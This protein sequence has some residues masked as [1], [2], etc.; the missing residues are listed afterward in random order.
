MLHNF[1]AQQILAF[2]PF[3]PTQEQDFCI[4]RMAEFCTNHAQN[5]IFMLKGYAGTGKTSVVSALVRA[6]ENLKQHTVLLAPTGRA[7]KVF[8]QYSGKQAISIHKKIYRQKSAT[9][10]TF[11]LDRNKHRDTLFIVD[12]ASM[13][14]NISAESNMFGSGRLLDDLV[15]YVYQAENCKMILLG[16]TAQLLPVNQ[17]FSPALDRKVLESLSLEVDEFTL[18]E[19]VRQASDSGILANA[20]ML[21][22]LLDKPIYENPKI[23]LDFDDIQ[24][25]TGIELIDSI[26][27]SYRE[28]GETDTIVV[29]RSNKRANVFNNGIR[30]QVL[31]CDSE[32][33][34]G[35][36]LMIVKNNYFWSEK[37]V[38]LNFIA[39]GD[40][41]KVVRVRRYSEMYGFRFVDAVLQLLDYDMEI[42]CKILLNSLST[43]IPA[44]NNLLGK[45]LFEEVEKD[46]LHIGNRRQRYL[47]MRE[48]EYFNALQVKF[49]YAVTCHKSQGGQWQN[50]YI[51]YGCLPYKSRNKEF[52]QWLY[53]A[54]TRAQKKLF[55]INF[56]KDFLE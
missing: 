8:A 46:Y 30:N 9:D 35:D 1:F 22:K 6:M 32:I 29:T 37:Y 28:V 26:Y 45:Q 42:D 21:R 52:L 19:V 7:A 38:Q 23:N 12:E 49:S 20:T 50:V 2:L 14:A 56:E 24:N 39:N 25:I 34:N 18:T 31:Q 17:D 10:F 53:T 16:D 4:K 54:V 43:Q 5:Q 40:I 47:Q 51:D 27:Q 41:A 3:A 48:N 13:I 11:A 15:Q 44:D 36:L 33:S 55:L